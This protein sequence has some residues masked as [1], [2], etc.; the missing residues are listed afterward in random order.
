MARRPAKRTILGATALAALLAAG[1]LVLVRGDDARAA[2]AAPGDGTTPATAGAS[3]WGIDQAHPTSAS[4]VYWLSNARLERPQQFYCDMATDGGGWVLVGRGRQGWSFNPLGQGSAAMVRD[5]VDGPSAFSPAALDT[6]TIDQLLAGTDLRT[7]ADGI[8]VERSTNTAGT[9]RQDVRLFPQ[10]RTWTWSLPGGNLLSKVTIDGTTYQGSNTADTSKSAYGQTTNGLS[11]LAGTRRLFT[12][13]WASHDN[14]Q[15]FSFGSG[16][17]GGSS[18]A[19]NHLW[20]SGSEGS[21]IPF[22]RVWIRPRIANDAAGFAPLPAEGLPASTRPAVPSSRSERAGWG[23]VGLDHTGESTIEPWN[24][25]VL[26]LEQGAGRMFVGGRFTGVQQGPDAAP[27][28][29]ASLAAF[30]LDGN[31]ISTFR[32]KVAGRVWNVAMT[33]DGKL[34][35]A[36]DFTD[37]DGAPNTSGLA[38]LDPVTGKVVSGFKAAV[39]KADGSRPLVRAL[40]VRGTTAYIAGSFNRLTGGTWNTISVSSAASF[41]T[42]NGNPTTWRPR[43][44]GTAVDVRPTDDG[45]RV[46]VAG[47]FSAINGDANHGYFGITD[48]TSGAPVPGIGAWAPS[49][50]TRAKYQQAVLDLGDRVVVGGS[51]HDTQLWDRDRTRLIDSHITRAGGD[52]QALELFDGKVF[53]GCHCGDVVYQGTNDFANPSGFRS[54]QAINLVGALD[55]TTFEYDTAWY[56][57]GLKG[58]KGEGVWAIERDDRSCLWVGGDLQRGA[59]SG[60]AATDWLGGFARFCPADATAPTAPGSLRSAPAGDG[61]ALTWTGSTDASG[62]VSYD[63]YRDDRVI[64]TVWGTTFTD[65]SVTG[66]HRYTVRA[67]D[68]RGNRSASPA[69]IAVNGPAPQIAVAVPFGATWAYRADGVDLGTAWREAGFD[70]A[71]WARGPGRLGWGV[72][73]IGT[74]FATRP[75][76]AYLRS[77]FAVADARAVRTL[78]LQVTA[79][80][81]A[82][83]YLNGVEVGRVNMPAGRIAASTPAAGY[84]W[85]AAE[86]TVHRITVPGSLL[87]SGTNRLA[88]EL[89]S[90]TAGA[91]RAFVDVQATTYGAGG[92]ATAPTKPKATAVAATAGPTV[93]WTASSDDEALGGYLVA[94]DGAPIAVVGPTATTFVDGEADAA[95]AHTYVVTAFDASGNPA[96]S[97]GARATPAADPNL[98]AYGATWRWSF[99]EGGPAGTWAAPGYDDTGW[100]SGPAELGYGDSD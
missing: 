63:V 88:V 94:R 91:S 13:P 53:F 17:S 73:P 48:A 25:N 1:S 83:V 93:T 45:S 20:T 81:G 57:A 12:T 65:P 86:A 5:A 66:A 28:A 50:P 46:L 22:T 38:A 27:I 35:V 61:I 30:D 97:N 36:G 47:L 95:A 60:N 31:W 80:T 54:A 100:A 7:L 59:W 68:A 58:A 70:D 18:S 76:T 3:C 8:R 87:A 99:A 43:L 39:T 44:N 26:A 42:D 14:L 51:E 9:T 82:V 79:A 78:D 37:I 40:A 2:D 24:T 41:R 98:L 69:P 77:S 4:G 52:T 56:P 23:V 16:I 55:A 84:V 32:P 72:S 90:M 64:A 49:A 67:V 33:G 89:H 92:D 71:A 6:E 62:T 11:G 96:A 34:L 75:Q 15:G 74:S 10:Y 29:Q 21:P 19:T 85:G